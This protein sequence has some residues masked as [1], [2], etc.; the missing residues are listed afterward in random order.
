MVPFSKFDVRMLQNVA[1]GFHLLRLEIPPI[2]QALLLHSVS[3]GCNPFNPP[4]AV[5]RTGGVSYF[6]QPPKAAPCLPC[7]RGPP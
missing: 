4:V 2:G 1:I 5:Q 6:L 7:P 3:N